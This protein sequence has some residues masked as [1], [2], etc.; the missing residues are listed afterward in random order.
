MGTYKINEKNK[1]IIN[2][3][4]ERNCKNEKIGIIAAVHPL[5]VGCKRTGIFK[6]MGIEAWL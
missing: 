3:S 6:E 2:K 4:K 1:L 5:C